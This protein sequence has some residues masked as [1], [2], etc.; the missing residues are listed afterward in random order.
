[1][2]NGKSAAGGAELL[3]QRWFDNHHILVGRGYST[4]W[5][6]SQWVCVR[7]SNEKPVWVQCGDSW[8]IIPLLTQVK[9]SPQG[10]KFSLKA[11]VIQNMSPAKRMDGILENTKHFK[12]LVYQGVKHTEDYIYRVVPASME[13]PTANIKASASWE[14]SRT[15]SNEDG[16]GNISK[17]KS[18][19]SVEP[20]HRKV[21]H[22]TK[23]SSNGIP[24]NTLPYLSVSTHQPA[25]SFVSKHPVVLQSLIPRLSEAEDLFVND[26]HDDIL[27]LT[28][29]PWEPTEPLHPCLCSYYLMRKHLRLIH[30]ARLDQSLEPSPSPS[31]QY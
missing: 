4:T 27:A 31:L 12:A 7:R 9:Q 1:M 13:L 6:D 22:V 23:H 3:A 19:W 20:A 5:F 26:I 17:D 11:S 8:E 25:A 24:L 15:R 2:L 21:D 28:I 29:H 30:L 16:H 14:H 18:W 10:S